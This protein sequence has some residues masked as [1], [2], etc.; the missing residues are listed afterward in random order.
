MADNP[1]IAEK[2]ED[3][4][5]GFAQQS[6]YFKEPLNYGALGKGDINTFKL[7]LEQFF[8]VLNDGRHMGIVVPSGLYTDQG[9]Q[10]LRQR[11]FSQSRV[12]FLYGF[13]NRWPTVFSA[14]DGR[15]K[16]ITFGTQKGGKTDRFKCAFMEHDPERLPVIDAN[17]LKMS[18][19]QVRKFS[20]DTLSV[21][22][23]KSQRDIDIISKIYEDCP[24]LSEKIENTWNIKFKREL[25]MTN[26]VNLL[27][28]EETSCPL[29]EGKMI[30][31]FDS[32]YEKPQYWANF[33]S[34]LSHV[35]VSSPLY[36][37][38][39]HRRIS[40]STNE[41]TLVT[42]LI[43]GGSV[44][45]TNCTVIWLLNQTHSSVYAYLACVL[46]SFVLDFIVRYKITTTL[47]MFYMASLPVPRYTS[48]EA[49]IKICNSL[50]ARS[51]RLMCVSDFFSDYWT[52]SFSS[53][54][55]LPAF[56]YPESAPIDNYGPAHDQE[57]RRRLRDEAEK[58]TPEWAPHCGVHDRLPDRRDTG[59][60]AQLRAEIDAYV[61]H[62][63]GLSRDDFA[64]ILDTFPVLKKKEKKAFGEF[65]SKRKCLEEYDRV[66]TI[67]NAEE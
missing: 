27:Q 33:E 41:R 31:Q 28:R 50:V 62:L 30:W 35:T 61:A 44:G 16:F 15:F 58:L 43:P 48:S 52:H 14:V 25:D 32:Y 2:W 29:Y 57:I 47:N 53:N 23:F 6:A 11:F 36:P 4:C 63:Y 55:Q 64:Y 54:W 8:T 22:E 39:A 24:L 13:E 46:N 34:I 37:R 20:P 38:L 65:M 60:R 5:D 1:A 42:S 40:A 7:F 56:W 45:E 3:Y 67:M 59:D 66:K 19:K 51:C 18:V 26:A 21:M 17:V 49:V 12:K 9:C 10:P